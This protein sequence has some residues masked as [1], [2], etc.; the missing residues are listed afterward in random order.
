MRPKALTK[1]AVK[2]LHSNP[3]AR[4]SLVFRRA[5]K[6][7]RFSMAAGEPWNVQGSG[8]TGRDYLAALA[9][10]ADRI[11]FAG[12]QL[13]LCDVYPAE[14]HLPETATA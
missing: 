2:A 7:P 4:F 10:G 14:R 12:G 9:S 5:I 8:G 13:L 1:S 11:D 3:Q 6:F